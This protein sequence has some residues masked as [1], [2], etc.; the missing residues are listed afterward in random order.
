MTDNH[1]PDDISFERWVQHIFDHPVPPKVSYEERDAY[2]QELDAAFE[3]VRLKEMSLDD[4]PPQPD[5]LQWHFKRDAELWDPLANPQRT[6]EYITR[7][8]TS[9]DVL[10]LPYTDGQIDQGI[11]YVIYNA[12]SNHIY[13]LIDKAVPLQARLLC[14]QSFY[15]VYAKLYAKK[16]TPDLGHRAYSSPWGNPLNHTCYMWWDTIA[17]SP[18]SSDHVRRQLDQTSLDVMAKTLEIDHEACREGALHGLGHWCDGGYG[19]FVKTT[20]DRFLER[21]PNVSPS[22][23]S[24][25]KSARSGSVE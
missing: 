17:L 11:N 25:A 5:W 2:H 19:E 7:L 1:L 22:L 18:R 13:A 8:F 9:I 21:N 10:T 15:D 20:I 16:C 3:K 24:Y 23:R 4:I 14:V 12:C 6:V